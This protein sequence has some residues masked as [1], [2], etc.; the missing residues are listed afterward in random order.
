MTWDWDIAPEN[1][2]SGYAYIFIL[3]LSVEQLKLMLCS[4]LCKGRKANVP[5]VFFFCICNLP[6]PAFLLAM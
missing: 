3:V 5:G 6:T 2:W 4:I 1:S